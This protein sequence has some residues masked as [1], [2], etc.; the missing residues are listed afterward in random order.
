MPDKFKNKYRISS[1]RL[2]NWDYGQNASYF[3]TICTKKMEHLFGEII[4][5]DFEAEMQL[6]EIGKLAEKYWVEIPTH[7]SFIELGNFVV[8]PN[9]FHGILII[10]KHEPIITDGITNGVADV[11]K[12]QCL[13]STNA[14]ANTNT[15]TNQP[16]VAGT[17]K[18]IGQMRFQNQGKSTV[19]SIVGAYKS[20]VSKYAHLI[21]KGFAWQSS[22]HDHIIRDT[23]SFNRIQNYIANNPVNWKEDK[24]YS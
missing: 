18:T 21:D 2:Q 14:N 11:E 7:F 23:E 24:F 13:F 12:R 5:S 3:I 17:K 1:A 20:V 10:Y 15:N 4:K 19:S 8:M 9:H 22:F 6:N 16:N